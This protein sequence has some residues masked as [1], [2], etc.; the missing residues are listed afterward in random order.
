MEENKTPETV[1]FIPKKEF[2]PEHYTEQTEP[3]FRGNGDHSI[4]QLEDICKDYK[5]YAHQADIAF[6]ACSRKLATVYSLLELVFEQRNPL[7][8][9][10]KD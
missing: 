2:L 8:D 4:S 5:E 9:K 6:Y 1:E 10:I 3:L 7:S